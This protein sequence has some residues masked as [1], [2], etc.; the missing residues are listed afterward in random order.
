MS[1]IEAL[2]GV[3]KKF[4]G[5]KLEDCNSIQM[6]GVEDQEFVCRITVSSRRMG[7]IVYYVSSPAKVVEYREKASKFRDLPWIQAKHVYSYVAG[8]V[9]VSEFIDWFYWNPSSGMVRVLWSDSGEEEMRFL[10]V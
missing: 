8:I 10:K 9:A 1:K 2:V 4:L 3:T 7:T 6:E 5:K